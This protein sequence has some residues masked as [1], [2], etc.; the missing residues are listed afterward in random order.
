MNRDYGAEK[1]WREFHQS[2]PCAAMEISEN[3]K[4]NMQFI[5]LLSIKYFE[6]LI[7]I[8]LLSNQDCKQITEIKSVSSGE[9]EIIFYIAGSIIGKLLHKQYKKQEKQ[10]IYKILKA[11]KTDK[12]N[13]SD[14]NAKLVKLFDRGG[15]TYITQKSADFFLGLEICFHRLYAGSQINLEL[16]KLEFL[17]ACKS[18]ELITRDFLQ[19]PS[20]TTQT[21]SYDENDLKECM[22]LCIKMY[23]IIRAHHKCKRMLQ[24]FVRE[25]KGKKSKMSKGLRTELKKKK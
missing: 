19:A 9:K 20:C 25:T 22:T 14:P 15:L 11:L 5:L 8:N 24:K 7:K 6:L 2:L 4:L 21:E 12:E 1:S 3:V 10:H 23:F 16:S 13:S 18:N 17:K